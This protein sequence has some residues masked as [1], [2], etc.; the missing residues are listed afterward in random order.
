MPKKS[1]YDPV[2][3]GSG[4]SGLQFLC[5]AFRGSQT[6]FK[7]ESTLVIGKSD[8]WKQKASFDGKHSSHAMG[9]SSAMLRLGDEA[10]KAGTADPRFMESLS[11]IHI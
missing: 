4:S 11:L 1:E 8:R 9:Q 5:A 7:N 10:P 6:K 3:I 2:V